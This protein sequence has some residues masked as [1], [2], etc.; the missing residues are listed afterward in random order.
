MNGVS[1]KNREAFLC[2]LPETGDVGDLAGDL[3]KYGNGS[4]RVVEAYSTPTT[5]YQVVTKVELN[6]ESDLEHFRKDL[7]DAFKGRI[8]AVLPHMILYGFR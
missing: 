4:G 1:E 8:R 6:P 7:G 3:R 5:D 2:I